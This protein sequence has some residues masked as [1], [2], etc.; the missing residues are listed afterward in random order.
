MSS[1]RGFTLIELLFALVIAG[2]VLAIAM[3]G[4]GRFR[5][6]MQL[7]QANAQLLQDVRRARQLAITRRAPVVVRFGAPPSVSNITSYTIHV[8]TNADGVAQSTEMITPRNMP[9]GTRLSA[10]SLTPVDSLRFEPSGLLLP[11]TTGG[12]LTFANRLNRLDTLMVSAAGVCY[13]P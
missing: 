9:T 5:A 12:R 7:K 10:V 11:G 3:P 8:D 2:I 1:T 4:F 13:R 6:S